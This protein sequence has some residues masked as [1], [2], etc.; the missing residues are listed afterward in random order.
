[1]SIFSIPASNTLRFVRTDNYLDDAQTMYNR[2][3]MDEVWQTPETKVEYLQKFNYGDAVNIQLTTD[4]NNFNAK[5]YDSDDEEVA[6]IIDQTIL[7]TYTDGSGNIVYRLHFNTGYLSG[8]HY[9]VINAWDS[10][11]PTIQFTSEKIDIGDFEYLPYIQWQNSDRDGIYWDGTTIFGFRL[12]LYYDYLPI[13]ENSIYEGFNFQPETLFSVPKR[14]ISI[15]VNPVPRYIVEKLELAIRHFNFWING[16]LFSSNGNSL[17]VTKAEYSNLYEATTTLVETEYEDYTELVE[18]QGIVIE[19][20]YCKDY[21]NADF[22]D[23]DDA[24]F[25]AVLIE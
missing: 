1:M 21:D 3:L 20:N 8:L 19:N 15:S 2:L 14:S 6:I 16:V 9:V 22:V 17:E 13:S 4:Y 25:E 5:L 12:E 11:K 24:N 23:F 7:H 10:D 18:I